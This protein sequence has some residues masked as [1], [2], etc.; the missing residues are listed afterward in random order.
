M[1]DA[2]EQTMWETDDESDSLDDAKE[3]SGDSVQ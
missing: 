2:R 1:S 3:Y